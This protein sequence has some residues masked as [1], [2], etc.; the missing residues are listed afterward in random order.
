M[1]RM[2]VA[3]AF[4]VLALPASAQVRGG[5]VAVQETEAVVTV[6]KVD[7]QARVV[8]FRG[9]SGG[10][11]TL[12]VPPEAQNLDKVS[13]G[14]QYRMR[15]VEAIAIDIR[16]GGKPSAAVDERVALAPKGAKPGGLV[17]RTKQVAGV[18]EAVDYTQ[19]YVAVRGPKGRV[20]ALKVA[21]DVPLGQ[22]TAG[23]RIAVTYTEALAIE[24]AE[25]P[26]KK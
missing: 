7:R 18:V 22:F 21:D 1:K 10:E 20:A 8:T 11:A 14:Q 5:A 6:I 4:A 24:M 9:P 16:K 15:Y 3:A 17:V 19:R 12:Q 23:D 2:A 13:P 26:A 25:K